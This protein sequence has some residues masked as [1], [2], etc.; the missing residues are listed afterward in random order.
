MHDHNSESCGSLPQKTR[1]LVKSDLTKCLSREFPILMVGDLNAKYWNSTLI[2]ARGLLLHD[3]TSKNCCLIYK[4]VSPVM[5]PY[6]HSDPRQPSQSCPNLH[7]ADA[8]ECSFCIQLGSS[9]CPDQYYISSTLSKSTG[10]PWLHAHWA[11]FQACPED[12]LLGNPTVRD[13]A[14]NKVCRQRQSV[15]D[16]WPLPSKRLWQH[17]MPRTNPV[18][19]NG[20]PTCKQSG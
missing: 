10:I 18:L 17:M 9:A 11:A 3:Y 6:T 20:P 16:S 7:P 1:S 5:A 14:I 12:R 19:T 13:E 4:L 2:T 8:S 15:V